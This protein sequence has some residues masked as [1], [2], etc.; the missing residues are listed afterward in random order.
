MKKR[1]TRT[2]AAVVGAV[3]LLLPGQFVE[4]AEVELRWVP[5]STRED[6]TPLDPSEIGGYKIY[7]GTSSGSYDGQEALEGA[8]PLD[9]PVASL[10]DPA[11]PST[12]LTGLTT[13][14]SYFI[15][16]S[17]Y[18]TSG[19]ESSLS[20]EAT[21]SALDAPVF[22]PPQA[23]GEGA[24]RLSWSGLPQDDGGARANILVHYD[25]DAADPYQGKGATQG[26]SPIQR[27]GGRV[28]LDLTGLLPETRYYVVIEAQCADGTSKLSEERSGVSG[29]AGPLPDTGVDVPPADSSVDHGANDSA[30][31]DPRNDAGPASQPDAAPPP[32]GVDASAPPPPSND[33]G[34]PN[35]LAPS[36]LSGGCAIAA[37]PSLLPLLLLAG[38]LLLRRTPL[39]YVVT[40]LL[41]TASCDGRAVS[42]QGQGDS[43]PPR[44][45]EPLSCEEGYRRWEARVEQARRCTPG[46]DSC[47]VE[48]SAS[49]EHWQPTLVSRE[50][51][52][53]LDELDQLQSTFAFCEMTWDCLYNPPLRAVCVAD[54]EGGYCEVVAKD[55]SPCWG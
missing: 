14:R 19:V 7:Y 34:A 13:C 21:K 3:L 47:D 6:G 48:I 33:G 20:G 42:S 27:A 32:A 8:S 31:N 12:K 25:T 9:I 16:A 51:Q 17:T 24:L 26:D 35:T 29:G 23:I 49:L 50:N 44:K 45:M 36:K 38:L 5:P 46:R 55:V 52:Q 4:A 39:L 18:D 54:E 53:V 2:A 43:R 1:S 11:N 40:L 22:S 37:A 28:S 30:V 15:A 10:Q 41:L